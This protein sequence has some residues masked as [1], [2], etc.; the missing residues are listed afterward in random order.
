[1]VGEIMA[2]RPALNQGVFGDKTEAIEVP[3]IYMQVFDIDGYLLE[4]Q[5]SG[6][7]V[8]QWQPASMQH[9]SAQWLCTGNH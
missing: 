6:H 9:H 4:S 8:P 7:F 2:P 5:P 3:N 1:M